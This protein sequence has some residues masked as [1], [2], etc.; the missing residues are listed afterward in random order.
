MLIKSHEL[1]LIIMIFYP[2]HVHIYLSIVMM[3]ELIMVL[4]IY[5]N[6][7]K[8]QKI[9]FTLQSSSGRTKKKETVSFLLF[10]IVHNIF[11]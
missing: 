2:I 10:D 4:I 8:K 7:N 6:N 5:N 1:I 11:Y 9:Y 3:E